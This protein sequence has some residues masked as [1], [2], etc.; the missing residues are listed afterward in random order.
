MK[1]LPNKTRHFVFNAWRVERVKALLCGRLTR[2]SY[3]VLL[4]A[5]VCFPGGFAVALLT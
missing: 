5:E 2:E 4:V 3:R 1:I